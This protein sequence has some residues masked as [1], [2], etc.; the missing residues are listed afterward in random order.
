MAAY[1]TNYLL[2]MKRDKLYM[3]IVLT[4]SLISFSVLFLL[5]MLYDHWGV[6]INLVATRG[7]MALIIYI[8]ASR[9]IKSSMSSEV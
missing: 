1:G 7:A 8:A 3:K 4:I 5:V 2:I 9:I 6:A